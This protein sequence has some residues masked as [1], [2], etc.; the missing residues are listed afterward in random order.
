M[1]VTKMSFDILTDQESR[2]FVQSPMSPKLQ[3]SISE[4]DGQIA[5]EG[6]YFL[7]K[8]TCIVFKHI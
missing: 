1:V 8:N 3:S 4:E 2:S 5:L 6:S 7:Y